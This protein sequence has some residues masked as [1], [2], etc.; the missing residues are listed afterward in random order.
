V[1]VLLT[2]ISNREFFAAYVIAA[3]VR[4]LAVWFVALLFFRYLWNH[5]GGCWYLRC[6]RAPLWVFWA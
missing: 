6:W 2:P 3:V 1:F 4:G 5:P